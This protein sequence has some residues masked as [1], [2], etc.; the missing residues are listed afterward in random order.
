M[1]DQPTRGLGWRLPGCVAGVKRVVDQDDRRASKTEQAY[2]PSNK[3]L[4][5]SALKNHRN[6]GG[7]FY[8]FPTVKVP[9][10]FLAASPGLTLN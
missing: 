1:K 6:W 9:N 4:R 8:G 7:H 5:E 10:H 3:S 2:S